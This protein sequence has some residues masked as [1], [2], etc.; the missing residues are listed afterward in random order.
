MPEKNLMHSLRLVV[1]LPAWSTY[2]LIALI[3]VCMRIPT[4]TGAYR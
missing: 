1:M 4:R 2:T 3:I